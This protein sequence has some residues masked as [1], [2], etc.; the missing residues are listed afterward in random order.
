MKEHSKAKRCVDLAASTFKERF[1]S[2]MHQCFAHLDEDPLKKKKTPPNAPSPSPITP[3]VAK[4]TIFQMASKY[5]TPRSV[6]SDPCN[7]I[8]KESYAELEMKAYAKLT[9]EDVQLGVVDGK[10]DVLKFWSNPSIMKKLPV[11]A[12]LARSVFTSLATEAN[13]ERIFNIS[14]QLLSQ[15]RTCL[16]P[17]L[18]KQFMFV[19]SNWNKLPQLRPAA[20]AVI[21]RYK[22]KFGEGPVEDDDCSD[23]ECIEVIDLSDEE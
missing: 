20:S 2:K 19:G 23:E 10:F 1:Y 9:Y 15:L 14:G 5:H 13:C 18:V 17:D 6:N 4:V 3:Q 12:A 11:H 21:L 7:Q 22:E 8:P 16:G